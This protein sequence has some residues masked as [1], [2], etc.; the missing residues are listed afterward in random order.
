M[1]LGIY[2]TKKIKFKLVKVM[3]FSDLPKFLCLG[4]N[5]CSKFLRT[6]SSHVYPTSVQYTLYLL[7]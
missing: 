6:C 3:Q 1:M 2:K 4:I 7:K 5:Y